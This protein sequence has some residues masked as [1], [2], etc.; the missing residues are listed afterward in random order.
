MIVA[1]TKTPTDYLDKLDNLLKYEDSGPFSNCEDEIDSKANNRNE[2]HNSMENI[3]FFGVEEQFK[4]GI[5]SRVPRSFFSKNP[6]EPLC[7]EKSWLSLCIDQWGERKCPFP[8]EDIIGTTLGINK[9]CLSYDDPRKYS[10][11]TNKSNSEFN[12][13]NMTMYSI[14]GN[15]TICDIEKRRFFSKLGTILCRLLIKNKIHKL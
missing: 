5:R 9:L 15:G 8:T 14:F 3:F 10:D 7:L 2:T 11:M 13:A 12:I 6:L 4:M 1:D